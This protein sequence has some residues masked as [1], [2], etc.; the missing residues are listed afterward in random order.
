MEEPTLTP[1]VPENPLEIALV[2]ARKGEIPL[3]E[4]LAK[5]LD[6]DIAVPTATEVQ[7]DGSGFRPVVLDKEG[8][9]MVAVF[10]SLERSRRLE[11]HAR[12][13]L[14]VNARSFFGMLLPDVGVVLNPG[15]EEG[16]DL[17]PDSIGG[18]LREFA[19]PG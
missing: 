12:F 5:L 14:S 19:K 16:L 9:G 4:F 15:F 6:A 8:T 13:V 18:L 7:A 2:A 1:L 10:T 17:S 11:A 3:A